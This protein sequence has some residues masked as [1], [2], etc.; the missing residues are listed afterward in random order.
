MQGTITI[1]HFENHPKRI[2]TLE[3]IEIMKVTTYDH[4]FKIMQNNNP[5]YKLLQ[6]PQDQIVFSK[7]ANDVIILVK[8]LHV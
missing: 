6:S 8:G 3:E 5:L 1:L 2:N 7:N 4:M